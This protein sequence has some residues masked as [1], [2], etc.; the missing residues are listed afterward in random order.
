M[1]GF[2]FFATRYAPGYDDR[3]RADADSLARVRAVGHHDP[4]AERRLVREALA[5]A[6]AAGLDLRLGPHV[7]AALE[8]P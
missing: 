1:A 6:R 2:T 4:E 7:A 3:D 5:Q 8:R